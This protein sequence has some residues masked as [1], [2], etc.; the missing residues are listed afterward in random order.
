MS[1]DTPPAPEP[2]SNFK[3]ATERAVLKLETVK[4]ENEGG[5][6]NSAVTQVVHIAGS[7]LPYDVVVTR[8]RGRV[9]H[10]SFATMREAET[11]I[12]RTSATPAPGLSAL[13]DR[14]APKP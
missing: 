3:S 9:K 10:H 6:E 11:F 4:W 14:P 2:G 13:Y 5:H 7:A 1:S 8:P 12:R